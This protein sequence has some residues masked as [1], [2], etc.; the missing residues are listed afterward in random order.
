[1][2]VRVM[3]GDGAI[4]QEIDNEEGLATHNLL[5]Q[6]VR[7]FVVSKCTHVR[8]VSFRRRLILRVRMDAFGQLVDPEQ[9]RLTKN[10]GTPFASPI[11][12]S[13]EST[14]CAE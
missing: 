7:C 12:T 3:P 2:I 9:V 1:M 8:A 4:Q 5:I 10:H 13:A 6:L 11:K 14:V